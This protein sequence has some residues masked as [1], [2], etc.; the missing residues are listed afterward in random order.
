MS[1]KLFEPNWTYF[2]FYLQQ[3]LGALN[4]ILGIL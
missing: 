4:P 1:L 3:D 2:H